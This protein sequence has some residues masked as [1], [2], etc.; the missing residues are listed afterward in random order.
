M[1]KLKQMTDN[2]KYHCVCD[3]MKRTRQYVPAFLKQQLSDKA[4]LELQAIW[5]EGTRSIPENATSTEKY[6]LAYANYMWMARSTYSYVRKQ[7]GNEGIQK[8]ERAEIEM[9]KRS[10]SGL[11]MLLLRL[12]RAVAPGSAFVLVAKQT[13]HQ[14]QWVT[15][16]TVDELSRKKM[17]VTVPQCK[18]LSFPDTEDLCAIGCQSTYRTWFAEQLHLVMDTHRQTT[19]CTKILVPSR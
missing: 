6:E 13:A 7:L 16:F 8:F 11:T 14:L 17:V 4:V 19:G 1:A 10:N 2:E 15:P 3:A 5:Q 12:L 9:L 18:A